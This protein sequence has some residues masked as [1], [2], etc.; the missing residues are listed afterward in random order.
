MAPPRH[1]L[2]GLLIIPVVWG[3]VHAEPVAD[4]AAPS[5]VDSWLRG[6]AMTGGLVRHEKLR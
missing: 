4:R 6:P 3:A 2:L 1:F 5:W